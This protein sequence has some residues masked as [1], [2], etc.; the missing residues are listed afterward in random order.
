M[1]SNI[2]GNV[3][4]NAVSINVVNCYSLIIKKKKSLIHLLFALNEPH[5]HVN[6]SRNLIV[7]A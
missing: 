5:E 7:H 4:D 2:P 1:A 6:V 3:P